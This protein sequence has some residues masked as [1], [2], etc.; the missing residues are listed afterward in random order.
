M[1]YSG[2]LWTNQMHRSQTPPRAAIVA[3]V[4][5]WARRT[6]GVRLLGALGFE[7]AYAF[8][9]RGDAAAK[10]GIANLNDLARAAPSL[11]LGSDLEF[12]DRPEWRAVRD[13]YG[14]R[15]AAT[16]RYTPSFMYRALASGRVDTISAFSSDG[17]IAAD[18]LTVLADPKGAIPGYDAI[19]L[20]A[21]RDAK[22]Q[23]MAEALKPLIGAI[24][25]EAMRE[26][27]YRVDRDEGKETPDQAAA[28]LERKLGL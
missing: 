17:R 13:A 4:A 26:A 14:L 23:H 24:P 10:A 9:M 21:P 27:N 22:D 5:D 12:L 7:N 2:T 19:L 15:F 3:G 16:E 28:W 25:V 8:A 1:D 18:R 20:L 6:S 11:T